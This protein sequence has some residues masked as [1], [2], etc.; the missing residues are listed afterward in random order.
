VPGYREFLNT[1]LTGK[2]FAS[3]PSQCE[4]LLLLFK[5]NGH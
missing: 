1:P 2:E 4:R 3:R 5:Q